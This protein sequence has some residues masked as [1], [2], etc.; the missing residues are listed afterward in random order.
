MAREVTK[1][2]AAGWKPNTLMCP[3]KLNPEQGW[4]YSRLQTPLAHDPY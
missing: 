3:C 2:M 1:S 4:I